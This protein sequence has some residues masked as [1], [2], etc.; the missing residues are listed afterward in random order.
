MKIR[1]FFEKWM[2][3]SNCDVVILIAQLMREVHYIKM[4]FTGKN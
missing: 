4:C 2:F 3:E 1:I